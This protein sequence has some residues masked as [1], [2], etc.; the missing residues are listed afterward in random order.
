MLSERWDIRNGVSTNL[1]RVFISRSI[2]RECESGCCLF[3]GDVIEEGIVR[4]CFKASRMTEAYILFPYR[5]SSGQCLPYSEDE[6]MDRFPKAYAYLSKNRDA[7]EKRDME[8]NSPWYV[9]ARSQGL[10]G[11]NKR[12]LAVG[13]IF[14][15]GSITIKTRILGSDVIVYSG[16]FATGEDLE[17]LE[18]TIRSGEFFRYAALMG[19]NMS[20]GY[21]SI[22]TKIIS[23]YKAG[24]PETIE[25]MTGEE[26]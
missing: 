10:S 4:Q 6:L 7:L 2:G 3:N 23:G 24:Q 16:A 1:D 15:T 9:F 5:Y 22:S 25:S 17:S 26:Q 19:K 13:C 11:S 21:K 14:D 20:G 8:P 18:Q 12:K